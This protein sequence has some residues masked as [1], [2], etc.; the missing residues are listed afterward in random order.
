MHVRGPRKTAPK[1]KLGRVQKKNNWS[2]TPIAD[3]IAGTTVAFQRERP[4]KGFRHILT[5]Q[6]LERFISLLPDWDELAV[7]LKVILLA[8]GEDNVDGGMRTAG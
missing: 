7:G 6:H 1:V 5:K 4:A 8:S 3:Y 2:Y